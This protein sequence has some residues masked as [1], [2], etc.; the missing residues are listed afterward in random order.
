[1]VGHVLE[2]EVSCSG[3]TKEMKVDSKR[4]RGR[5]KKK[6]YNVI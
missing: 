2:R 1:M 6:W 3:V 5:L 4:G